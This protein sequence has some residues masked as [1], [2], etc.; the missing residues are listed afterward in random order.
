[1]KNEEGKLKADPERS[2]VLEA[3][4]RWRSE[5]YIYRRIAEKLKWELGVKLSLVNVK[6]FWIG[7]VKPS[8]GA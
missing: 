3:I 4:L 7:R 2:K 6:I 5:G 8:Y 1:L